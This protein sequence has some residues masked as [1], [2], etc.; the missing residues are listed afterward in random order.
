[1]QIVGFT[2]LTFLNGKN[3]MFLDSTVGEW[4]MDMGR[5]SGGAVR[6][7]IENVSSWKNLVDEVQLGEQP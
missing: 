6:G 2:I 5:P 7:G 4:K 3:V 1:M